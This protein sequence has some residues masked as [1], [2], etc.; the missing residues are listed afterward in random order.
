ML[1]VEE[2]YALEQVTDRT[3]GRSSTAYSANPQCALNVDIIEGCNLR[4]V[5]TTIV[6]MGHPSEMHQNMKQLEGEAMS[7]IEGCVK[8]VK[9]GFKEEAGRPL[10]VKIVSQHPAVEYISMSA[11]NP[12]RTAY[13]RMVAVAECE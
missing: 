6:N 12:K 4:F 3:W 1:T 11:Y 7:M 2:L 13:Y 5:Y 9:A 10:K 8:E